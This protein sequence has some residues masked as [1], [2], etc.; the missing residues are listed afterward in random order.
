[1]K[2]NKIKSALYDVKSV[3][4]NR[5]TLVILSL[6]ILLFLSST[7]PLKTV[8]YRCEYR[9]F[10][11]DFQKKDFVDSFTFKKYLVSPLLLSSRIFDLSYG[12]LRHSFTNNFNTYILYDG[13]AN[14]WECGKFN[15]ERLF[16]SYVFP[17]TSITFML[18]H[19]TNTAAIWRY[20]NAEFKGES[21]DEEYICEAYDKKL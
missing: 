6:I 15:Q 2:K 11:S 5:I 16:C 4:K 20:G 14:S 17:N 8:H 12:D 19:A 21:K 18:H 7:I 10:F 3:I 13:H 9:S 1:M